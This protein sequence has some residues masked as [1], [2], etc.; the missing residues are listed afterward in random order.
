MAARKTDSATKLHGRSKL[1]GSCQGF[2]NEDTRLGP[3]CTV[4]RPKRFTGSKDILHCKPVVSDRSSRHAIKLVLLFPR[5]LRCL[6]SCDISSHTPRGKTARA[7]QEV[8]PNHCHCAEVW[9][10]AHQVLNKSSCFQRK[11]QLVF[12]REQA[13]TIHPHL[14]KAIIHVTPRRS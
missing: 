13:L 7:F 2:R 6:V 10:W 14:A 5:V 1:S 4:C 3:S 11:K 8:G 9:P 12:A